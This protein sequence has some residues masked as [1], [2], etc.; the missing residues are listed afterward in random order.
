M[1]TPLMCGACGGRTFR[2]AAEDTESSSYARSVLVT[3]TACGCV[4]R[5]RVPKPRIEIE[6]LDDQP[7]TLAP[8]S[9]E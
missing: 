4:A 3:C 8:T 7:G 1:T 6:F 9:D 2:L 5:L